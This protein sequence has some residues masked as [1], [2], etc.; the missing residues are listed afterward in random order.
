MTHSSLA[1][2]TILFA[3]CALLLSAG[4]TQAA[5]GKPTH[6]G[7]PPD[8]VVN[9]V[10]AVLPNNNVGGHLFSY[11]SDNGGPTFAV[12]AKMVFVV[13]DILIRPQPI[14]FPGT[15]A[16]SDL[17][18]VVVNLGPQGSRIFTAQFTGLGH[19]AQSFSGGF[20]IQGG[21][22]PTARNTT[23]SA[24]GVVVQ[25]LGYFLDGEAIPELTSPF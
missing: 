8:R 12:P 9:V 3:A 23:F 14:P 11:D 6:L 20:V 17:Y 5:P 24:H 15:A 7:V 2:R 19:F 25:M 10:T 21:T 4:L 16:A 1:A 18:L 13:T 22:Q